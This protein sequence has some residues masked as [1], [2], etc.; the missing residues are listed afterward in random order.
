MVG[1]PSSELVEF[2]VCDIYILLI[3]SYLEE[4]RVAPGQMSGQLMTGCSLSVVFSKKPG[5]PFWEIET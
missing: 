5:L 4:E 2:M 3:G 1:S